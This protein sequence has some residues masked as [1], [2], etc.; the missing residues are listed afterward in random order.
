M[1]MSAAGIVAL[2]FSPFLGVDAR[3]F[4]NESSARVA[5]RSAGFRIHPFKANVMITSP[6]EDTLGKPVCSVRADSS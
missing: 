2:N 4:N 6:C 5:S 3:F 1:A